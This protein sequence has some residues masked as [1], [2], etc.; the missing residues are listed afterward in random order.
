MK[1]KFYWILAAMMLTTPPAIARSFVDFIETPIVLEAKDVLPSDVLEGENYKIESVVRNDGLVNSYRLSSDYGPL[2]VESTMELL[3]RIGELNAMAAMEK[4]DQKKVFGDSVLSGIKAPFQGIANLVKE[5]VDTAKDI[6]TGT[7]RFFSNIGRSIVSDDPYQDNAFK[8]AVGYD[9]SKRA[10]AFELGINPYSNYEPAMSMLGQI[11]QASVA[12]GI[13]PKI[14]LAAVGNPVT[15]VVNAAGTAEGMRKLVRDNS[16]G[17][18]RKINLDKL[19]K[20]G[21][22]ES[23]AEAFL[24]NAVYDPQV[25][26]ILTGALE[27]LENV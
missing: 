12:G 18:L 21:I 27:Q 26:T 22:S 25:Q 10:N 9:A 11:A 13:T 24:S 16:P 14:A 4:M 3:E 5:P 2:E 19:T 23:L 8:V 17:E 15:Q 20:M 7:G 1:L 6:V